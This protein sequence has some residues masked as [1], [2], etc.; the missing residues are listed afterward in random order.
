VA[1]SQHRAVGGI[2][3]AADDADQRRLARAVRPEQRED[4]A[5]LDVQADILERLESRRI[6]LG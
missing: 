1:V 6:L 4:F 2:D 3:D 5:A